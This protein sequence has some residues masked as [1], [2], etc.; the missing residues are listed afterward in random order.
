MGRRPNFFLV[1][2]PKS[3]TTAMHRY[4]SAHPDVFMPDRKEPHH[5]GRDIRSQR[6]VNDRRDYLALFDKARDETAVGE[7]SVW[8]MASTAAAAEIAEFEPGARI[9]VMLRNP[10]ELV[11]SL[12]NHNIANGIEDITDLAVALDAGT[13]RFEKRIAGRPAIGWFLDYLRIGHFADQIARFQAAFPPEQIHVVIYEEFANDP[14]AAFEGVLRFIGVDGAFRPTFARVNAARRSR[15]ATLARW[16]H[17]PPPRLQR[18]MRAIV[19]TVVRRQLWHRSVRRALTQVNT[20]AGTV[21]PVSDAVRERLRAEY[22]D[23][24][25]RTAA[26]IGRPDLVRLWGYE[27]EAAEAAAPLDR[28]R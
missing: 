20:F 14:A 7:A 5:F 24:V 19:P 22:S 12:H 18:V 1:G 6:F 3:G 25:R 16:L 13:A 10:A 9:L 27:D 26:L 4:L 28:A 17:A 21:L 11:R 8:Y 23:D 2:A 15:S